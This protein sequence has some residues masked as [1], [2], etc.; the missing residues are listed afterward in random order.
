M[1]TSDLTLEASVEAIRALALEAILA[2]EAGAK[3]DPERLRYELE[4]TAHKKAAMLDSYFAG[5]I[6]R[7]EMRSMRLQYEK[8]LASL[9]IRLANALEKQ[10]EHRDAEQLKNALRQEAAAILNAD[11]ESEAFCKTVLDHITVFKDRH[12]ELRLRHLPQVFWFTG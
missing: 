4:R 2:G 8:K 11:T 12:L 1:D 3:D 9:D 5:E 10:A 7:E 6:T